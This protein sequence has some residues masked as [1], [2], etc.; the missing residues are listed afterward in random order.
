[1]P[2][3]PKVGRRLRV[4]VLIVVALVVLLILW[5]VFVSQYTD[6]LWFRSVG[7]SSVFTR[8]LVTEL[9][10]FVVFGLAMAAVIV[11]NVIVAYRLRPPFR[12][13]SAEQEQLERYRRGVAPY[14]GWILGF[15]AAVVGIIAGASASRH[16][17]T[18]LLWRNRTPFGRTDPQFH[19]DIS[20]FAFTYPMQRFVLNA[21]IVIVVL[22]LVAVVVTAYLY[23]AL[24][25]Q[26]PGPKWSPAARAHVSILLGVLLLLKAAAYYLDRFGLA[27]SG[28][29]I[30]TGPSYTDVHAVLPAKTILV[31]V[32]IICALLFFANV[33]TRNW[34]LP[35]IAFGLMALSAIIIG[36][37][38]PAIVQHFKVSPSAQD[39]E[40]PYISRNIEA[41]RYAYGIT[42]AQVE[43]TPDYPGES[44][45]SG[46]ALRVAAPI[47]AQMRILDPNVVSQTFDQLQ[48]ERSYYAFPQT[49]DI[50][51]YKI[52]GKITD[53]VIGARDIN[54]SGLPPGEQNWINEHLVYTHGY[55]VA[56][57]LTDSVTPA[58]T[59][60]F[61]EQDL[62]PTGVLGPYQPRIYFGESSP[63]YSIVGAPAG[64]RDREFDR[65]TDSAAGQLNNTYNGGGG[66]SVGSTWRQLLYA[67]KFRDKNIL[68][69]SGV[70]SAS[71]ILYVRDPR[72][73]VAKVAPWL[74]LD[75][76]PYPV[77]ADGAIDWV[78]DGYTTT[79]G[80]PYSQQQSLGTSTKTSLT[81]GSASVAA[82]SNNRINYIRNSVKAIVNAYTG[83]VTLYA[84]DQTKTPQTPYGS[85]DPVLATWSKA[86]PG[87]V[88]P[89][90]A[91]PP[92]LL[93]HLRYPEDL[94]NI[95]R[96]L[97]AKYHVTDP[98]AF[99]NGT[100]FW[101]VPYDPTTPPGAPQVPQPAYYLSMSPTGAAAAGQTFALTSPLVSLNRRNLTAYLSVDSTPGPAYGQFQMLVLPADQ[102]TD[103]PQQVQNN[104]ES[105]PAISRQL[106]LLR[107]GG[108][109]VV[110]GNLLTIPIEGGLLYIEPIYVQSAAA[111]AFPELRAV[112]AQYSATVAYQPT[113]EA[114]LNQVFG[115]PVT[116]TKSPSGGQ[117]PPASSPPTGP[118]HVSA[119]LA[120]A[121]AAAQAAERAAN[122]ALRRG[123]FAAYGRAQKA[124]Q[125]A[126]R[127]IGAAAAASAGTST[128]SGR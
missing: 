43:Q 102:V 113:L 94:F 109:R 58:G 19:R 69:S 8:R 36:G 31:F 127:Q 87:I 117:Q 81:T 61:V 62:P 70:N 96:E 122:Q 115:L 59:P 75:G 40:A 110:L 106:S 38:Y 88:Q 104:I 55:G 83:Q 71:R 77:V 126:L 66:V 65:P 26:T 60:D 27:F 49:L 18:W 1:M 91:I 72:Q 93:A 76:D 46:F 28:R 15:V 121:I 111:T 4:A 47:V 12:P 52:D 107:T 50:D 80:F 125:E 63:S 124:L 105:T 6:L 25:I 114:A 119:Q 34:T 35:A 74:T 51:R 54:L 11:A 97:L 32:A 42:T 108:S 101:N 56:A 48:Q 85:P 14:R 37:A 21:L 103:G 53:V 118:M 3:L 67:W 5:S 33:V 7:Y 23:G 79:D 20:Y 90:S 128:S 84:W 68:L 89:Q 95:Q 9:L 123:D 17:E 44:T 41:T 30:V 13:V 2:S 82:Q 78:V 73:R 116:T 39:L 64:A 112:A 120:H 24:R 10:L 22:S 29:G 86:F 92:A 16:W 57:A 100:Q 98:R 45:K 99:Y